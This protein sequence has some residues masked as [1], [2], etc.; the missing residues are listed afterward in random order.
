MYES[1][2]FGS[3]VVKGEQ[4]HRHGWTHGHDGMVSDVFL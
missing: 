2:S 4:M 3:K 1:S